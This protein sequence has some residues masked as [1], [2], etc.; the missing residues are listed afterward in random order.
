MN[1][2][3]HTYTDTHTQDCVRQ[4]KTSLLSNSADVNTYL[5]QGHTDTHTHTLC[6]VTDTCD[7]Q[8]PTNT[9]TH[10]RACGDK[11]AAG[12]LYLVQDIFGCVFALL[13]LFD[14]SNL[15]KASLSGAVSHK[16]TPIWMS[17]PEHTRTH[18][19]SQ[20]YMRVSVCSQAFGFYLVLVF[21]EQAVCG[22]GIIKTLQSFTFSHLRIHEL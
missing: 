6:K 7:A 11:P 14:V 19:H 8:P 20:S 13:I 21:M 17:M 16:N 9:H 12:L 15:H 5:L 2:H 18:T 22:C 3:G 4:Y 10:T 1:T